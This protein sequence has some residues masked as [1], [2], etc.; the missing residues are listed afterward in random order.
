MEKKQIKCVRERLKLIPIPQLKITS[1]L[2]LKYF[3]TESLYKYICV[4][5]I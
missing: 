1:L 2:I 4:Y 5:V 3:I